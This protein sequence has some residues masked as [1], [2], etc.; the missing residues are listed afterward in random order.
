MPSALGLV[1]KSKHRPLRVGWGSFSFWTILTFCLLGSSLMSTV[2]CRKQLPEF[3]QSQLFFSPLSFFCSCFCC[4]SSFWRLFCLHPSPF[5]FPSS[6]FVLWT[7]IS[8]SAILLLITMGMKIQPDWISCN[9]RFL[10]PHFLP[11]PVAAAAA[12]EGL[13]AWHPGST[14]GQPLAK[15]SC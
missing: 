10:C 15:I 4:T 12:S 13:P 6:F 11:I 1:T 5:H 9:R 2:R 8:F 7:F 3:N 14:W